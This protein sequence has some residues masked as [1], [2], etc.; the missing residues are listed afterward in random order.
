M[1]TIPYNV[2]D[3]FFFLMFSSFFPLPLFFPVWL[4]G[5]WFLVPCLREH[6]FEYP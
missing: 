1:K 2:N 6:Q 5:V 4:A 3:D